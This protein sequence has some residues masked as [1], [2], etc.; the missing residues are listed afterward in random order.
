VSQRPAKSRREHLEEL[1]NLLQHREPSLQ[2]HYYVGACL[3]T[4]RELGR[5]SVAAVIAEL[6][7]PKTLV[8][9]LQAARLFAERY[10]PTDLKRLQKQ[11]LKWSLVVQLVSA[12]E[13]RRHKLE[14]QCIAKRWTV[15]QL[16]AA[17]LKQGQKRSQGGRAI[18][19]PP[20]SGTRLLID[21]LGRFAKHWDAR[22]AI[23][24]DRL[25]QELRKPDAGGLSLDER[26]A[27]ADRLRSLQLSLGKTV[28]LLRGKSG[29]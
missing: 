8:P 14:Q 15:K 7:Q 21:E 25:E 20:W 1:K 6:E 19:S 9:V 27:A 26:K 18:K 3:K 28:Q 2:W 13:K 17:I 24:L 22:C 12:P 23:H 11:K 16:N 10:T 5:T 4:I 29:K